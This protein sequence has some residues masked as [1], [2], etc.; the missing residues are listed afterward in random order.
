M[1]GQVDFS[2]EETYASKWVQ[3]VLSS[4][5]NLDAMLTKYGSNIIVVVLASTI[6]KDNVRCMN[7]LSNF[8]AGN[9]LSLIKRCCK[10]NN[11]K[12]ICTNYL[13]CILKFTSWM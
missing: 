8:F 13:N 7:K 3:A 5:I 4:P 9:N 10:T 11:S 12:I 6:C 1:L 2:Q